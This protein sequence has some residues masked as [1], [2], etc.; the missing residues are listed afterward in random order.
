[1]ATASKPAKKRKK[2]S[3]AVRIKKGVI[4][5][6]LSPEKVDTEAFETW[7][8]YLRKRSSPPTLAELCEVDDSPLLWCLSPQVFES[9][10]NSELV[11]SL[12]KQERRNR[13]NSTKAKKPLAMDAVVESWLESLATRRDEP[14]LAIQLLW[15]CHEPVSYTHLTLPTKRIV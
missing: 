4:Q 9:V 1:M 2:K 6:A 13:K 3:D 5:R 15:I 11:R 7:A 12:R 10:R 14:L 8:K